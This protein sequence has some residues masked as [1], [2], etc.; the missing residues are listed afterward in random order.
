MLE[1][2]TVEI[3]GIP[4]HHDHTYIT[5]L[6]ASGNARV[7]VEAPFRYDRRNLKPLDG[8]SQRELAFI[9]PLIRATAGSDPDPLPPCRIAQEPPGQCALRWELQRLSRELW[10]REHLDRLGYEITETLPV[11]FEA[12]QPWPSHPDHVEGLTR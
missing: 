2:E 7:W 10:L 11:S 4:V 1:Y 9:G 8:V 12:R 5:W 3:D 6:S